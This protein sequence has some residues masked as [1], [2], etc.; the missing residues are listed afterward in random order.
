MHVMYGAPALSDFRLAR[1]L[2][3]LNSEI[4]S[5]KSIETQVVYLAWFSSPAN[6]TELA[7]LDSLVGARGAAATAP[8][9]STSSVLVTPRVG[10]S[11]PW[12]SK[13]TEIG[14]NCGLQTLQRLER[15]TQWVFNGLASNDIVAIAPYIHDRMTETVL[16]NLD[17]A[18]ALEQ[19][20]PAQ[21]L[22]II[23]LHS[24]G[25]EALHAANVELGL[26][27]AADE[28]EYLAGRYV[29]LQRDPTDIELMMF[30]Q[31]NSEHC[32]H[33]IFNAQWQL[34]GV[35]QT[36]SLF[37]MVRHTHEC[38]P[39]K[40]LSAYSDNCA[41][42]TGYYAERFFADPSSGEYKTISEDVHILMKVE[43]HNHPT[44]ISPYPGAATGSGGEI[45]DE[46]ATGRG[47]K[48]KAGLTGF[49]VS[50]L[51]IPGYRRPWET[52]RPLN[53]RLASAL[54][55]MLEGPI[56]AAAFNNEF[57]RPALAG[58]FR[59]FEHDN[60]TNN[61]WGYDKPI[62]LA[63]GCGNIRADHVQKLDIPPATKIVVLGGPA[64]LIGLGGGAASSMSAGTSSNDLDFASVQRDNPEM[65]RR[66]QEVINS[67]WALGESNPILSIHD[68][69]A[70]GLSNAIPEIL[71]D[72]GRGGRIE[73][74]AIPSADPSMS[75]LAIWCNE[76][77]ERYVIAI[78][79]SRIPDFE[80]LC[81]RERC[82][83][84]VVGEAT[85]EEHLLV[86]D[87][88]FNL[89][90]I[91]LPMDV[92]FGKPPKMFREV[93]SQHPSESKFDP[94][95]IEIRDALARVLS[96]ASVADKRFL[97]TIADRNVG[98]LSA[99]DQMVGPWQTPVA[100]CAVTASGFASLTG[101]AMALGERSPVALLNAPASGRLAVGEALTNL[102]AARIMQ[103]SDV[104]LSANWMAAAGHPGEDVRLFDT[105]RAVAY[106][107]CPELE[108]VIPVGK[109]S[110]S[111]KSRWTD[112]IS[113]TEISVTSPVSLIISAFAPVVDIRQTLTPELKFVDEPTCLLFIDLADGAQRTGGSILAQCYGALGTTVPDF[114]SPQT[115]RDF[116]TT[117]QL[118]NEDSYLL[119]YHDRSDG[120]LVTSLCEMAFAARCGFE[121]DVSPLGGPLLD[122]LF[123]EELGA[124]VQIRTKDL[125][126]VTDYF[127]RSEHLNSAV[128]V[129]GYPST[130]RQIKVRHNDE[131]VVDAPLFELLA[132]WS[133]TSSQ[134]Q[135]V[136]DNP[137]CA[138]QELTSILDASDP[139]LHVE[140]NFHFLSTGNS[141]AVVGSRPKIAILREQ[142]VNGHVEMAAAFDRAGFESVDVH[143][144]DI[145]DRDRTLEGFNGLV[146]CGGFSY[147]DVLGAGGGWAKSILLNDR[148]RQTFADFFARRSTFT[149]GVCNGCQMLSHLHELIP[150]ADC[151][152]VFER[153]LSEQF[154]A[155]LVMVEVVESPSV[156]FRDMAGC[157]APIVVAH[158]EG[159]ITHERPLRTALRFV[160]NQGSPT[161]QYPY[162][163]NGS[164]GGVTG[165][166]SDDGRVTIMM[167]HPE[168]VFLSTQYSWLEAGWRGDDGP[169]MKLFR[170][171][172][173]WL[174]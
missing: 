94:R 92:I 113:S 38:R 123:C 12:S 143:M 118:L 129:L 153:N 1:L 35:R 24:Q 147:G 18:T 154:E 28:I 47:A 125:A 168:R 138:S 110:M 84:A 165:L 104:V 109:D 16:D 159:R 37:G 81:A 11:S 33:K 141:P 21:A 135:H 166:T 156:L 146:A 121:V 89:A 3:Q 23:E 106:E 142:G 148:A 91:D 20:S 115:M 131:L 77:Q 62:M 119:A 60:A 83:L 78:A 128:H 140:G 171:A 49:S 120:G 74:R 90:V 9:R 75:P 52:N 29:E 122:I 93:Q 26:A 133:A 103:L 101:E 43:T 136:R 150:G 107:L 144:S 97:I 167:P 137:N 95:E 160:D 155:R 108:I 14:I 10:T 82:P 139:G 132:V 22:G 151:W 39:N 126:A 149:L 65:E 46:G 117:I 164:A 41:V 17:E 68:V 100:D 172:R 5:L 105:V 34:D 87:S 99:R 158:G 162:N 4:P 124:V 73:L 72:R 50:N 76:A 15:A 71:H 44:G 61:I 173:Q 116:F 157:R 2:E 163:P 63:G 161:S 169:W 6:R 13:A 58:Y 96:H 170:N 51:R 8:D 36:D 64:M 45:R 130:D 114:D 174:G 145:I 80:R 85:S 55:I 111:M 69:G 19:R 102:A 53:P 127:Q 88:L 7:Q 86:H 98:G 112:P 67:C 134:M 59:V 31:A 25:A 79:E 30:A 57:G 32:R 70:G 56:G 54:D 48:P 152:P 40:V 66:C 27:L 42:T